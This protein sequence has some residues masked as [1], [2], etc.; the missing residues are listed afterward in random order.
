MKF[1]ER[2]IL[3]KEQL[4]FKKAFPPPPVKF[5]LEMSKSP[6]NLIP[7][8]NNVTVKQEGRRT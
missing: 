1:Q 3:W 4:N 8:R 6:K 5:A 2:K 7:G